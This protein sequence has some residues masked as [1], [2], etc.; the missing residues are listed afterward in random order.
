MIARDELAERWESHCQ[1]RDQLAK[2]LGL[3]LKFADAGTLAR[4]AEQL[5]THDE[6]T[7]LRW[8]SWQEIESADA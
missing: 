4:Q 1:R 6:F 3:Q 7:I 5:D 8:P 2:R